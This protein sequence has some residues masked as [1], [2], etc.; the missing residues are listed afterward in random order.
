MKSPRAN[1]DQHKLL[2]AGRM[3]ALA[4]PLAGFHFVLS[5]SHADRVVGLC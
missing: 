2:N 4:L 5:L 1:G 3:K